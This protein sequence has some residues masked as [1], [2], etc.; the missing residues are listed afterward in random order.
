MKAYIKGYNL[1]P[2]PYKIVHTNATWSGV[3]FTVQSD[4]GVR[5]F[6]TATVG[7][8]FP[9]L[10]AGRYIL[11]IKSGAYYTISGGKDNVIVTLRVKKSETAS[12]DEQWTE[13]SNGKK[14]TKICTEGW[15]SPT[16]S[17]WIN[18]GVTVDTVIYP[19]FVEG[20]EEKPY[21]NGRIQVKPVI[22]VRNPKNLIPFPYTKESGYTQNGVTVEYD[23]YGTFTV[24][25]RTTITGAD[26]ILLTK[27]FELP[28]GDYTLIIPSTM[29]ARIGVN[30]RKY[31]ANNVGWENI[32]VSPRWG[33][34]RMNFSITDE[35]QRLDFSLVPY[36][37]DVVS[38]SFYVALIK[39][40]EVFDNPITPQKCNIFIKE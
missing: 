38:G 18:K 20:E 23:E 26:N 37:D 21:D 10:L 8:G 14:S 9:V 24:N 35:R 19:M 12:S 32:S 15:H 11:P 6:G 34:H 5:V 22:P 1:I 28:V 36:S 7:V 16:V 4:G 13:C 30:L 40:G 33:A 17:L 3:T 25:G 2:F 31:P 29:T 27:K 39:K